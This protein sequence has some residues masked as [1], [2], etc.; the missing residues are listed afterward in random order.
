VI[1]A[2]NI[3]RTHGRKYAF[4]GAVERHDA[5]AY[6]REREAERQLIKE[7]EAEVGDDPADEWSL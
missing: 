5:G 1:Y 7:M 4:W 6:T 3:R 2:D